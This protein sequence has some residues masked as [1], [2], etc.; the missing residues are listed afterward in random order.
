M[1][2]SVA[3]PKSYS[4]F[5]TSTFGCGPGGAALAPGIV[6]VSCARPSAGNMVMVNS[7]TRVKTIL[8]VMY[9]LESDAP[10]LT[11]DSTYML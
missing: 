3:L 1:V 7:T 6:G 4:G 8:F 10:D 5:S 2:A 11:R 9:G